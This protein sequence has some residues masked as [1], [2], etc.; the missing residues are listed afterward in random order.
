MGSP[1]TRCQ[2][3]QEKPDFPPHPDGGAEGRVR[4]ALS[5]KLPVDII[6]CTLVLRQISQTTFSVSLL[7]VVST[8][9]SFPQSLH[10]YSYIGIVLSLAP[11]LLSKSVPVWDQF[12]S[13][14]APWPCT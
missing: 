11:H 14:R 1:G 4:P 10:L 6:F 9:N 2:D 12:L 7:E 13:L 3:A 8:S 5:L